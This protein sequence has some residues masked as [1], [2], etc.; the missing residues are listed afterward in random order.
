M[1]VITEHSNWGWWDVLDGVEL[2]DQESLF[3]HFPNGAIVA[4]RITVECT[5]EATMDMG[6][7][8][9]AGR[10][11]AYMKTKVFGVEVKVPLVGLKAE[12]F[13]R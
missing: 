11:K 5:R 3:I 4:T 6:R 2:K 10:F 13:R 12:R 8:Y 1:G 9:V 7:E